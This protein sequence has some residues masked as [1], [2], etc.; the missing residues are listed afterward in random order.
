MF[1]SIPQY[2]PSQGGCSC[3][4]HGPMGAAFQAATRGISPCSTDLKEVNR[5]PVRLTVLGRSMTNR[6]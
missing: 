3:H 4:R 5:G 1:R 6:Q 2:I